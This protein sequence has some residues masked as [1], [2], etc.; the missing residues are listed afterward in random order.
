MPWQKLG[1]VFRPANNYE[2]MVSHAANPV[3]KPLQG[4]VEFPDDFKIFK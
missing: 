4:D 3:A 2:W 1:R